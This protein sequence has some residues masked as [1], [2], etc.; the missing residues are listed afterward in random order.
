MEDLGIIYYTDNRIGPPIQTVVQDYIKR[1]GLSIVS[2]SL[3]PL[4]FGCNVVFNGDRGYP[5]YLRQIALALE[6]Q[7]TKYVYFCE[8]DVLYP[9]SHFTF[10][11]PRDDVWYY[12]YHVYRWLWGTD[13]LISY[14]GMCSLSCLCVNREFALDHYRRRISRMEQLGLDLF[15]SREPKKGRVW[16]YEPGTKPKRRGGFSNDICDH[17]FSKDPIIDIRHRNTFS[18]PKCN[19]ENFRHPPTGWKELTI[20]DLTSWDLNSVFTNA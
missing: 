7:T 10:L 11:P 5:T 8:H 2:C 12:N 6:T 1:S 9:Q 17:W 3:K 18:P 14:N 16:G 4:D 20:T 13:R 15:S 19:L